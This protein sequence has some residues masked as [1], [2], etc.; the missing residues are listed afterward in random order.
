MKAV[1]LISILLFLACFAV[2][3]GKVF[4]ECKFSPG[5]WKANEWVIV[6]SPRWP[7]VGKWKQQKDHISNKVPEGVT[8]HELLH[9]RADETYTSMLLKKKFKGNLTISSTM[10]FD[11]RMAPLLV[12]TPAYGKDKK[13]IPEHREH[14]EIVL[15]DK[16]L[17][18]WHHYYTNGKP[19]WRKAAYM[20]TDFKPGEKYN[21]TVKLKFTKSGPVMTIVCGGKE[22]GY[23]DDSLPKEYYVGLT[24]CEG[25]NRFYDFKVS[26]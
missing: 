14:F 13:G 19:H 22:F 25:I 26:G 9:K 17:N 15:F 8:A 12:I 18:V 10:S 2:D 21:L 1:N 3:A 23:T 20:R 4:Y 11:H 6:K 24:A 5:K 16:G 7:Y